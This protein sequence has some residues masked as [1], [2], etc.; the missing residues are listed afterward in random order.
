MLIHHRSFIPLFKRANS[1]LNRA[2]TRMEQP[3][4]AI[5]VHY[6]GFMPRHFD[7]TE[8][9]HSFFEACYVLTGDGTYIEQ[10]TEFELHPGTL[11]LSRPGVQHEIRS[12]EAY[13]YATSPLNWT[14][15][16]AASRMRRHFVH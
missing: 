7:N 9:R 6:W 2:I 10:E 5:V 3:D 14:N 12:Q 1:V 15:P 11:F 16:Q 4:L 8:H 13:P